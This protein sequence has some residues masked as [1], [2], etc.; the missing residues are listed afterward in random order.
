MSNNVYARDPITNS[1]KEIAAVETSAGVWA[2][3]SDASGGGGGG[4]TSNPNAAVTVITAD[5]TS[6]QVVALNAL[7]KGLTIF[8]DSTASLY[9]KFGTTASSS[10]Y[11]VKMAAGSYYEVPFYYTG[12]IDGI[13]S[14]VNGD[15]KVTEVT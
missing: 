8:N 1:L 14:A 12:R 4:G 2:L 7:R 11:T 6:Q 10:S 13:W 9:L 5:T 3:H 15:A